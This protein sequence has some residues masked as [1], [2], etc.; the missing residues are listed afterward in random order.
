[1]GRTEGEV[2]ARFLEI[3]DN[4]WLALHGY[5]ER[6]TVKYVGRRDDA[7]ADGDPVHKIEKRSH[8]C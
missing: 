7:P 6:I 4:K 1:M 5:E 3:I 2:L 8:P